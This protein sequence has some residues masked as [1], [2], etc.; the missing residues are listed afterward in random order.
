MPRVTSAV[1]LEG[2]IES[3]RGEILADIQ[4]GLRTRRPQQ[5][6]PRIPHQGSASSVEEVYDPMRET[7]TV[8]PFRGKAEGAGEV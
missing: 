7:V 2:E 3:R 4:C 1:N 5:S 6:R 8:E